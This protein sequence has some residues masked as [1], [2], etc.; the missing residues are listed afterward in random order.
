MK[1]LLKN[2]LFSFISCRCLLLLCLLF[3]PALALADQAAEEGRLLSLLDEFLA[4]ASVGDASMHDRFWASDLIYTSSSGARYGKAEIMLG[5]T[6]GSDDAGQD[7]SVEEVTA[8][9]YWAED[10]QVMVMG[11]TAV[12]AFRLVGE[13]PQDGG[14]APVTQYYFNT[15]TFRL[16]DGSWQAV[17]WQATRIPEDSADPTP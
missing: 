12:V 5:L 17:A 11:D 7:E 9:R 10:Q 6:G 13:T 16:R 8:P 15:G 4:G 1:R 3:S 2:H 14:A